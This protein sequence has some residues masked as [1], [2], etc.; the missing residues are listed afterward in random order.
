MTN[1]RYPDG[2]AHQ[3]PRF[4]PRPPDQQPY[5]AQGQ[6]QNPWAPP[7]QPYQP[8]APQPGLAPDRHRRAR[9]SLALAAL[10]LIIAAATFA[11]RSSELRAA[12]TATAAD[13][14]RA[15]A[16][17]RVATP[18]TKSSALSITSAAENACYKRPNA[19]G[20]IYLRML[21]PG[22]APVAQELGGGWTWDARLNECL[23]SVQFAIATAP[24]SAGN[25]TQVGYVADN[26]GYNV[27]AAT[28][29]PLKNVV[30]QTGSGCLPRFVSRAVGCEA[31]L[32]PGLALLPVL[33]QMNVPQAGV[34]VSGAPI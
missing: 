10:F 25:C 14:S 13:S 1:P 24:Q 5:P 34:R 9:N 33:G 20:D 27:N 26:P 12:P 7:D 23:T 4:T 21:Q 28:P 22:Q 31:G 30:A 17:T 3:R 32:E 19:S 11:I 15:P 16:S 8:P 29:A 18:G 2:E 6:H